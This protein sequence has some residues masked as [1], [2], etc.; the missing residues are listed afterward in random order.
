MTVSQVWSTSGSQEAEQNF[1]GERSQR[2]NPVL[3]ARPSWDS[4]L[5]KYAVSYKPDESL[6]PTGVARVQCDSEKPRN[7][8]SL[9][10]HEV[11]QW[12][13]TQFLD[14]PPGFQWNPTSVTAGDKSLLGLIS[15][16][17]VFVHWSS[18]FLMRQLLFLLLFSLESLTHLSL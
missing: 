1:W 6:G 2:S 16:D 18:T 10:L 9:Q 11:M 15:F 3:V 5:H 12:D 14:W 17:W 4:A 7:L 8:C 13:W